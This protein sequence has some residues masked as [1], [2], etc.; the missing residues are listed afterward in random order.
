M[1]FPKLREIAAIPTEHQ[2]RKML[3]LQDPEQ[4]SEAV[5]MI[6]LELLPLI[7]FF[8]G[9]HSFRDIQAEIMRS[10]GELI[11]SELISKVAEEL[12]QHLL[13]DSERFQ[14]HLREIYERWNASPLRPAFH[15]GTAYPA[16][17]E[18]LRRILDGYY[19][20]PD[21]PGPID[22]ARAGSGLK[23]ILAPHIDV[24]SNGPC[25]AHAYKAL[26]QGTDADL[27]LIFGT[28]HAVAQQ[29]LVLS[30]K[31][32]ETPLGL[33]KTDRDLVQQVWRSVRNRSLCDDLP[34]RKEH[35]IE[36][37][38]IFLQHALAGRRDFRIVPI[39]TGSFSLFAQTNESPA[40]DPGF[41]DWIEALRSALAGRKAAFIVGGDLAH[42]GPRYGDQEQYTQIREPEIRQDDEEMLQ[43]LQSGDGESFFQK[44][45][46]IQDRRRICGLPA[47]YA[48]L[49][50]FQPAKGEL[51]KWSCWYDPSTGSAVSFAAMAFR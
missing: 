23:G 14:Q 49:A 18:E 30:E 22:P 31:D 45:A 33:A 51:L 48:A 50:L 9:Q 44:I 27:F 10:T 11:D 34:H 6:P 7:R 3:L 26:A 47:I 37:Q 39:L 8:D 25:Y 36:F 32:Y 42:L 4:I 35:S 17:P 29:P 38:V 19:T 2:G 1:D 16:D 43:P 13:L 28:G 46:L 40:D 20:P 12:D 41:R 24:K 15:A 5:V 21:G